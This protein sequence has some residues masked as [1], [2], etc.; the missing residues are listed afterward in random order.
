MQFLE[1]PFKPFKTSP[2]KFNFN[3]IVNGTCSTQTEELLG[4]R[5]ECGFVLREQT[6]LI[7]N[8]L[9]PLLQYMCN[10]AKVGELLDGISISGKTSRLV[11]FES[12]TE[13][14]DATIST[15]LNLGR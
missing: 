11:P 15:N 1:N 8:T 6:N 10:S 2:C 12:V 14:V 4:S 7:F 3:E 9:Q 5:E 13:F